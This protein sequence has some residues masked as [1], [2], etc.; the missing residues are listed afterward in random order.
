MT[1]P[2]IVPPGRRDPQEGVS[3]G[4]GKKEKKERQRGR[5]MRKWRE[6]EEGKIFV[7]KAGMPGE[8]NEYPLI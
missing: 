2:S 3:E 5:G 1:S 7:T 4:P 6:R 8:E